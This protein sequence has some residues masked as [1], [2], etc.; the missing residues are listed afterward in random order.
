MTKCAILTIN[1]GIMNYGNRL[2]N[3]AL[4]SA[5]EKLGCKVETI[6]YHPTYPNMIKPSND[7]NLVYWIIKVLKGIKHRFIW[8]FER[9][10]K[11]IKSQ[12]FNCFVNDYINWSQKE[13]DINS[14]LVSLG[15]QYD[16]FICG[17][18]Q[19]W[20]PYWEGTNPIYYMDFA[21]K[22]KRITYAVSFGVDNIPDNMKKYMSQKI[23]D[24]D[25]LACREDVGIDLNRYLTGKEAVQVI[26]PVFLLSK[27]E[28][29]KLMKAPAKRVTGKKYILVY[30]LGQISK[31]QRQILK[32]IKA[33]ENL[34]I[35]YLDRFS[36]NSYYAEPREFLYF[37]RNAEMVVTDS[38]HGIAFSII[39]H[40]RIMYWNRSLDNGE[41]QDMSSRLTSIFKLFGYI[42]NSDELKVPYKL[43]D[44]PNVENIEK[45]IEEE[46]KK[47]YSYLKEAIEYEG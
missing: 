34:D 28:W 25:F 40:K 17:S 26:D 13:Y 16:Y 5:L 47:G 42:N 37:V 7:R 27:E 24:I 45:K 43:F 31:K 21:P 22:R 4:Q 20:N 11:R 15:Q 38:F 32:K 8:L 30:F 23:S 41:N 3:F 46:R 35:I 14:D 18:D 9:N 12:K 36:R 29:E 44:Y 10:N 39:F 1:V 6:N 33:D 19:V 2:Q